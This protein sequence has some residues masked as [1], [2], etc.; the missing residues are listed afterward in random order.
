LG[1]NYFSSAIAFRGPH[2]RLLERLEV[3]FFH[4]IVQP[5]RLDSTRGTH[6]L[7]WQLAIV[8]A[9]K[10]NDSRLCPAFIFPINIS[11]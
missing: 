7:C 8:A 5:P 4:E 1:Q 11:C 9:A 3:P 6:I 10:F 2:D